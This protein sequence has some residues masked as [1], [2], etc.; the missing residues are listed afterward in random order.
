MNKSIPA[1]IVGII[2]SIL[3][4]ISSYI[5]FT[6]VI[7]VVAFSDLPSPPIS[8]LPLINI[9]PFAISFI[10]SIVCMFRKKVGGIL[11]IVSA[12]ISFLCYLAIIFSI[13]LY[14]INVILF[15]IPTIFI[16]IAGLIAVKPKKKVQ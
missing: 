8:I 14:D 10:G 12:I 7:F 9:L 4:A 6:F 13:K 2:F 1:F 16:L 3:G 5:F 11:L 15:M